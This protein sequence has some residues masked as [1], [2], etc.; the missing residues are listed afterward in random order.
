MKNTA[1]RLV[2]S[3]FAFSFLGL[4]NLSAHDSQN[5]K[6]S[7]ECHINHRCYLQPG[8]LFTNGKQLQVKVGD[9]FFPINHV[10]SDAIGLYVEADELTDSGV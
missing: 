5:L 3:M 4:S 8:A 10:H 9:E 6:K 7:S 2:L 1:F